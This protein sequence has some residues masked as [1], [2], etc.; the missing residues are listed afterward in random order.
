MVGLIASELALMT[1]TLQPSG[2]DFATASIP[3]G[4]AKPPIAQANILHAG[5]RP[6]R[7]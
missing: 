6:F 1:P 7:A 2:A 3:S 4:P 5:W